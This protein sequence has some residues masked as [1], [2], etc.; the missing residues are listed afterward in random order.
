M[1]V[2]APPLPLSGSVP[3]TFERL[4]GNQKVEFVTQEF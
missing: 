3:T 4:T 2:M 1:G